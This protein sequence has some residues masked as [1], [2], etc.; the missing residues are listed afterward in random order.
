MRN[1]A[2]SRVS[3]GLVESEEPLREVWEEERDERDDLD[4]R[5]GLR[6]R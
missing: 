5:R 6:V 3:S 1:T 2:N 4:P